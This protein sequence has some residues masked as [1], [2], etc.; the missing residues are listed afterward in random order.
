[1]G[2]KKWISSYLKILCLGTEPSIKL[3]F[4]FVWTTANG[5]LLTRDN[6]TRRQVHFSSFCMHKRDDKSVSHFSSIV[7]GWRVVLFIA[8]HFLSGLQGWTEFL[9][10]FGTSVLMYTFWSEL[11][12]FWRPRWVDAI[13]KKLF[14]ASMQSWF[15]G[16]IEPSLSLSYNLFGHLNSRCIGIGA[17]SSF[18]RCRLLIFN[19]S[20]SL[21][22]EQFLLISDSIRSTFVN[23]QVE[24]QIFRHKFSFWCSVPRLNTSHI[25]IWL[26]AEWRNSVN[27]PNV[28]SL[29]WLPNMYPQIAMR[30]LT[31]WIFLKID[32][33]MQTVQ[34]Y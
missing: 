31:S 30:Y 16:G 12:D 18:C 25:F 24:L 9:S 1:M 13:L 11:V 20:Y 7:C 4:F 27:G 14:P 28:L 34:L 2:P 22:K 26:H 5:M 10:C 8:F 33:N 17:L 23:Y 19:I 21:E 6:F 15:W 32:Y 3:E 29:S